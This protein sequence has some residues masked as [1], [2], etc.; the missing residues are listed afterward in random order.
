MLN[1]SSARPRTVRNT[2]NAKSTVPSIDAR[3]PDTRFHL[4]RGRDHVRYVCRGRGRKLSRLVRWRKRLKPI[5]HDRHMVPYL[6]DRANHP[7][8]IDWLGKR[9]PQWGAATT[10]FAVVGPLTSTL[11]ARSGT[12]IHPSCTNRGLPRLPVLP[13]HIEVDTLSTLHRRNVGVKNTWN[14]PQY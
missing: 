1:A 5:R 2:R 10:M 7:Y 3:G 14:S 4:K 12:L 8:R 11:A 13:C 6:R 9:N